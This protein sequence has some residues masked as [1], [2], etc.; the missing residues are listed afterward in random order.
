MIKT[1]INPILNNSIYS[2]AVNKISSEIN[3][4]WYA[5]F[6][7]YN[8]IGIQ[9]EQIIFKNLLL[10]EEFSYI[11][12]MKKNYTNKTVNNFYFKFIC[13]YQF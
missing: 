12:I 9:S 7:T 2:Q 3:N 6:E 5:N 13:K 1:T 11:C 10:S 4:E 8:C